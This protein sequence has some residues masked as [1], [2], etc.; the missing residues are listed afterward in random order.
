MGRDQ[1]SDCHFSSHFRSQTDKVSGKHATVLQIGHD[2]RPGLPIHAGAIDQLPRRIRTA[3]FLCLKEQEAPLL[4]RR[5]HG[6]GGFLVPRV[7]GGGPPGAR[8]GALAAGRGAPSFLL[9]AGGAMRRMLGVPPFSSLSLAATRT[10]T[11]R[12]TGRRSQRTGTS[13]AA[14]T[15]S[16]FS[17]SS[18]CPGSRSSACTTL[19]TGSYPSHKAVLQVCQS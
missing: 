9:P 13:T 15:R 2:S 1:R 17:S 7:L 8:R 11:K 4:E 10:A 16:L 12:T 19:S 3:A 5:R 14:R 18:T 6:G